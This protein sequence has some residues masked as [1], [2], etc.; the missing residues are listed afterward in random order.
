MENAI[1]FGA[2]DFGTKLHRRIDSD[3]NI[4]GFCDNNKQLW[5]KFISEIEVFSPSEI[6]KKNYDKIVLGNNSFDSIDNILNQLI[7]L[8][9]D[10]RKIMVKYVKREQLC[11]TADIFLSQHDL[12]YGHNQESFNRYN[13]VVLYLAIECIYGKNAFGVDLCKKYRKIVMKED[14]D[15]LD[16][17]IMGFT[18]LIKSFEENGYEEGFPISINKYGAL[19]DGTHRLAL[20]IYN[21]IEW[22]NTRII[23]TDFDLEN[24]RS[25]DW[26]VNHK[27]FFTNEEINL[28]LDKYEYIKKKVLNM[29]IMG[30][31]VFMP[32]EI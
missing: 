12:F 30:K 14:I 3:F 27:D 7:E 21:N 25:I 32:K 20:L 28:I 29:C 24:G 5:G 13:L 8:G 18:C 22:V 1:I 4:I 23:D 16:E 17:Y 19:I 11:T 15:R 31:D 2:S 9:I 10:R 6:Y 26:I